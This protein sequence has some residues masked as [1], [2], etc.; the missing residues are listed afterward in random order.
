MASTVRLVEFWAMPS[1]K[2]SLGVISAVQICPLATSWVTI[3]LVSLRQIA[4]I[5]SLLML[6]LYTRTSSIDPFHP[7]AEPDVPI[8]TGAL[9]VRKGPSAAVGIID[10]SLPSKNTETC[11]PLYRP[12]IKCHS[13]APALSAVLDAVNAPFVDPVWL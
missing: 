1:L 9:L 7:N 3:L 5:C 2:P 10:V 6:K 13:P 12:A 11:V 8:S 4:W